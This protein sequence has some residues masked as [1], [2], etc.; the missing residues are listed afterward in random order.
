MKADEK[1]SAAMAECQL[2]AR[3]LADALDELGEAQ[4]TAETVLDLTKETRRLLDQMAYRYAKLQDTLGEKC[5]PGLLWVIEEPIPP[6][7]TFAEKLQRLERLEIISDAKVWRELR[8]IRIQ[9]AHE[10]LDQ[11]QLMAETLKRFVGATRRLLAE[12]GQVERFYL[13]RIPLLFQG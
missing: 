4:F 9:L 1:L 2:H 5:L 10:Y 11:P 8:E 3:V 13:M 7:A 12:W 6:T